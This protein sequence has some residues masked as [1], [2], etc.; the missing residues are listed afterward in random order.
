MDREVEEELGKEGG[1]ERVQ[2]VGQLMDN[3]EKEVER[4]VAVKQENMVK[5]GE[6]PVAW[7]I[8]QGVA[9]VEGEALAKRVKSPKF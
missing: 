3:K 2:G 1:V 5:W 9:K 4:K 8:E 6:E 7:E